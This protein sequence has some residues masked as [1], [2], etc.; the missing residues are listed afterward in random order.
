[1]E[2][3][4]ILSGISRDKVKNPKIPGGGLYPQPPVFFFVFFSGIAQSDNYLY[5]KSTIMT[6]SNG[7]PD[8]TSTMGL[9][10][11]IVSGF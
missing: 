11:N 8:R 1:M 3:N 9:F 2:C 5:W 4:T 7:K 10:A 6:L